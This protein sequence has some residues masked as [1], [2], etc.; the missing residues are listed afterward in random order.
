MVFQM[1][2]R[3]RFCSQLYQDLNNNLERIFIKQEI[4]VRSEHRR[5][6]TELLNTS[7]DRGEG[8]RTAGNCSITFYAH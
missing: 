4:R 2:T 3:M 8:Q 5:R 1:T 6:V 7:A